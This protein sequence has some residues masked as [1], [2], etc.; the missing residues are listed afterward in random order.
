MFATVVE[1]KSFSKAAQHLGSTQATISRR[2]QKL[3]KQLGY[4]LFDRG[5]SGCTLTQ[6]GERLQKSAGEMASWAQAFTSASNQINTKRKSITITTGPALA[7]LL[8]PH[9]EALKKGAPNT[10][11]EIISSPKFLDIEKGEADIAIRNKRPDT[12]SDTLKIKKLNARYLSEYAIYGSAAHFGSTAHK[13]ISA[14]KTYIWAGR[15]TDQSALPSAQWLRENVPDQQ[16]QYRLS[17]NALII[18]VLQSREVLAILPR[19]LG[20]TISSLTAVYGPIPSLE[21]DIWMVRR[22]DLYDHANTRIAKNLEAL[23][24][25]LRPN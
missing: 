5:Q 20:E 25:T 6:A 18:E 12:N 19:S 7:L 1:E 17:S 14:L 11:I 16:I 24:K 13:N 8:S 3:E 15:T 2:I 9:I 22:D 21:T 4:Q 10:S 23:L